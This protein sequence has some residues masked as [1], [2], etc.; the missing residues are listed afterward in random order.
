MPSFTCRGWAYLRILQYIRT[1]GSAV[2]LQVLLNFLYFFLHNGRR[3]QDTSSGPHIWLPLI[4]TSF[5]SLHLLFFAT[6]SQ[7]SAFLRDHSEHKRRGPPQ[8]KSILSWLLS[9]PSREKVEEANRALSFQ[10]WQTSSQSQ[11]IPTST[12]PLNLS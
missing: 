1:C 10:S 7:F 3:D 5:L 12:Q 2:F 4:F 9:V 11:G 6:K 8:T